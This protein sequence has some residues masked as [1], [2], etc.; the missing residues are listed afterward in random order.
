MSRV[1][2]CICRL[3]SM[4]SAGLVVLAWILVVPRLGS[5]RWLKLVAVVAGPI[6]GILIWAEIG[7]WILP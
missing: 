1:L 6:A 2:G 4:A 3:D 7:P 5:D